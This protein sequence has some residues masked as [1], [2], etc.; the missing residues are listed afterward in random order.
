LLDGRRYLRKM[1]LRGTV[2]SRLGGNVSW[3]YLKRKMWEET[4]VLG[5]SVGWSVMIR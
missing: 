2:S 4:H 5:R 1:R 3:G